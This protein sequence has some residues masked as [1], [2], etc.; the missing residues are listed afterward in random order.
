M[1]ASIRSTTNG[2]NADSRKVYSGHSINFV[3]EP[4]KDYEITRG[5]WRRRDSDSMTAEK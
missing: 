5:A 3:T 4:L 2:D 1:Q